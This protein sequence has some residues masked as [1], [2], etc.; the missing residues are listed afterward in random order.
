M[1]YRRGSF[2][3]TPPSTVVFVISL[4]LAGAALLAHYG[5]LS[6]PLISKTNGFDVLAVGYVVLVIGVLI[7]RI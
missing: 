2:V 1:A 5:N 6:L 4:L 3:L 7:R